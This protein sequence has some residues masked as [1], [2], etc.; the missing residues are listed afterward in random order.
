MGHDGEGVHRVQPLQRGWGLPLLGKTG[1]GVLPFGCIFTPKGE[2]AAGSPRTLQPAF[3]PSREIRISQP[4]IPDISPP[5]PPQPGTPGQQGTARSPAERPPPQ[6]HGTPATPALCT[7]APRGS[8]RC[9]SP[10]HPPQDGSRRPPP[11]SAHPGPGADG[12]G[13]PPATGTGTGTGGAGRGGG[14]LGSSR[15]SSA[16]LGQGRAEGAAARMR[17]CAAKRRPPKRGREGGG[18]QGAGCALRGLRAEEGVWCPVM[19][20]CAL[21]GGN[22][23]GLVP[24]RASPGVLGRWGGI[25]A[26]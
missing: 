15:Q 17:S 14:G 1:F 5:F 9:P 11:R 3:F 8:R 20:F 24:L 4:Q 10:A 6:N 19:G 25:P 13:L 16:P 7:G 23:L 12:S 21:G 18:G 26:P 22:E 2:R